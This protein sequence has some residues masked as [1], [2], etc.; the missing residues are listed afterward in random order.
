MKIY[1]VQFIFFISLLMTV[2]LQNSGLYSQQVLLGVKGGIGIPDLKNGGTPQSEGFSSRKAPNFGA[3]IEYH[4]DSNFSL[5]GEILYAG[6]G[7]QRNG[8]QPLYA[9]NLTGLPIPP[10]L[11][12]YANFDNETILNYLEFPVFACYSFMGNKS[13]FDV[14]VDL[15]LYLGILLNATAKTNG[16]STIFLDKEGTIPLS[17]GGNQLPPQNFDNEADIIDELNKINVGL[18]GGLGVTYNFSGHQIKFD[19]RGAYGFIRLQ[20]DEKDGSNYTGVLAIT[21]GYGFK[22]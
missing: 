7:G 5:L 3:F 20:A 4:F 1:M 13:G 8:M 15:G 17:V 21:L 9:Y 18:S 19:V 14:Y 10:D 16:T 22:I 6:Q 11:I 12:L 2:A